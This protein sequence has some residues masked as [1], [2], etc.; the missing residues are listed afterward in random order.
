MRKYGQRPNR[1][2]TWSFS[3]G[4]VDV[5][6]IFIDT[7]LNSLD[8]LRWNPNRGRRL[9]GSVSSPAIFA[10]TQS[11][12]SGQVPVGQEPPPFV[13]ELLCPAENVEKSFCKALLPHFSQRG[14]A[15]RLLLC[16]SSMVCP[17][18]L[19]LYSNMGIC[20]S[21]MTQSYRTM[22]GW[23]LYGRSDPVQPYSDILPS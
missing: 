19:H 15:E 11:Y 2:S 7:S 8:A 3:V 18:C 4:P 22:D 13:V 23:L 16:S 5:T 20:R 9:S 17:H 21:S 6:A 1:A 10:D 14:A 12:P